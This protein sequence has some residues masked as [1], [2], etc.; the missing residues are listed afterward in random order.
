MYT[1]FLHK[2]S[3]DV[4]ISVAACGIRVSVSA[5]FCYNIKKSICFGKR[6]VYTG[7][8]KHRRSGTAMGRER[9]AD[10]RSICERGGYTAGKER[11]GGFTYHIGRKRRVIR[12][13]RADIGLE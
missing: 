2:T 10:R 4:E 7:W 6:A 1:V 13:F 3:L 9:T 5:G 8:G 11:S 12:Q